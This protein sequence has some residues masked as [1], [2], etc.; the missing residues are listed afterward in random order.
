M[1][2]LGG[3]LFEFRVGGMVFGQPDPEWDWDRDVRSARRV[4][5][6]EVVVGPKGRFVTLMTLAIA[7]STTQLE[8][9]RGD[10]D[11]AEFDLEATNEV[12]RAIR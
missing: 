12:L 5:L 10:F 8:W 9:V 7:G 1:G 3:H 2:W 11:P 6:H 4:K